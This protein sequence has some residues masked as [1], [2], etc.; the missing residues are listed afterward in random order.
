MSFSLTILGSS[1]AFPTSK[2]FP[3]AHVLNVHERFF[4]ID[5]GE[6]TQIQMKRFSINYSRINHIF[7]SHLHGDHVFGLFGL[8]SSYTMLGRKADL[9]LYAHKDL[10]FTL[11]HYKR[12]FG[13]GLTYAIVF[14][15][16]ILTDTNEIYRDKNVTVELVPLRHSIPVA[17]FVFRETARPLNLRKEAIEKY[18]LGIKDIRNIKTGYD[19][20]TN[21]GETISNK[22]ITLPPYKCRSYAFCTDTSSFPKLAQKL[23][24]IDLLYY[25]STF[26]EKDKK[27]ARLT[28]HS[29]A[30]QAANMAKLANA[31][32]LLIGHFSTRYKNV[33]GLLK[34]ARAIFPNTEAVEDGDKYS[35]EQTRVDAPA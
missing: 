26:A 14:H 16:F 25:E 15:P 11:E 3:T 28:G 8:L 24:D 19:F 27:L 6:G 20:I 13:T 5:C 35:I 22:E 12:F 18:S 9:H 1:A 23:K 17:G 4:L 29:T 10:E 34:E 7:I 30:S 31:G 21:T 2:R 33:E 32:K